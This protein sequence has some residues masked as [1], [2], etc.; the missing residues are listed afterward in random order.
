MLKK[1]K[2]AILLVAGISLLALSVASCNN[3]NAPEDNPNNQPEHSDPVKP[4]PKPTEVKKSFTQDDFKAD[5]NSP[6]SS[7][8]FIT[9]S[10]SEFADKAVTIEFSADIKAK[11]NTANTEHFMWQVNN[12][13]S[14]P[15][16]AAF[17]VKPGE[18]EIKV[19][20]KNEEP[21]TIS[22]SALLYLSTNNSKY[23]IQFDIT[24]IKYTVSYKAAGGAEPEP[25][26]AI[27]YPTDIFV[28]GEAGTCGL[29]VGDG[30]LVPFTAALVFD[31]STA[32][33]ISYNDDGSVTYIAKA[34]GGAGGGIGFYVKADKKEINI[35]N[36]ESIDLE[37]VCSPITGAWKAGAKNPSF[38]MR[39]LPY[40]ST[41]MFGGFEDVEYFGLDKAYGT[42]T[43]KVL[44]PDTL[45][46]SLLESSDFDE[47]LGFG[48]KFNDYEQGLAD[49]D[50]LKVQIK[51]VTFNKKADAKE[52]I[53]YSEADP[54][55]DEQRGKVVSIH[56]PTR[57]YTVAEADLTEADYFEKH[58][59]VYMPAGYDDE[60]NKDKEYPVL[61]LLHGFG[62][63]ENTWGL[64]DQG[65]GGKIKGFMDRG[66]AAGEVEPFI[67][68]C[69]TG[70]ANKSGKEGGNGY[71]F[72]GYNGFGGEL[73]EKLLPYLR[74]NYR[75]S[76]DRND[77]AL[78]GLS[79]GASQTMNIGMANCL[80]L[81]S[82]FGAFSFT[83]PSA[84]TMIEAMKQYENADEL[85]INYFYT[86]CGDN[87]S[88][89]KW[90]DYENGMKALA[91]GWDKLTLGKNFSY[92]KYV[93]GTHDFPVWYRGFKHLIP[94]LFQDAE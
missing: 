25:E 23:D 43:K 79:M 56:Y 4:Q 10:L 17:D 85:N 82:W 1:L 8:A 40:D 54:L 14:Y 57:D 31:A 71:D 49:G 62:Q 29:K 30:D 13:G 91:E 41:G 68:V 61:I 83:A 94:I 55:T 35:A 80:D 22:S 67:L 34:S 84:S 11:N 48:I 86:I 92:E 9:Y 37:L 15:E 73:R 33:S 81:I 3:G 39:L 89:A 45:S 78:A 93:G 66:I 28:V 32:S 42:L 63:N 2:K 75:I 6:S 20:G 38:A 51:K 5:A 70:V 77:V 69:A 65:L 52:D 19:S 16:V 12:G 47:I 24:N 64:T 36:Y 27:E 58:A 90:E 21:I 7:W 72:S 74:E 26:P 87:D 60:A 18:S 59:W 88:V 76:D 46:A 50:Q 53:P 44:I